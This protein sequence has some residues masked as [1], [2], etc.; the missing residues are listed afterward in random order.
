VRDPLAGL[1]RFGIDQINYKRGHRYLTVVVDHDA[2]P[3]AWAAPGRDRSHPTEVLRRPRPGPVRRHVG[4]DA[5]RPATPKAGPCTD[6]G[7]AAVH[8]RT[9]RHTPTSGSTAAAR[10]VPGGSPPGPPR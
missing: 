8:G 5:R 2:K 9:A 10:P 3:L 1:R 7:R 4:N 6:R